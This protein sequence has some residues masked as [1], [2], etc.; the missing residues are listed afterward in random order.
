MK[1]EVE[2]SSKAKNVLK[3]LPQDLRRELLTEIKKL[4]ENPYPKGYKKLSGY[5]NFYRIR[6]HDWRII[7]AIDKQKIVILI[8]NIGQ[9]KDIYR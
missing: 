6:Y 1:F 2:I 7:Y 9:R 8:T 5:T 4:E 3:K